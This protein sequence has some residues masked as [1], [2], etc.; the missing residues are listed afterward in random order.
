L[1]YY[2]FDPEYSYLAFLKDRKYLHTDDSGV[3]KL[4]S[5]LP[6]SLLEIIADPDSL[7]RHNI[8]LL[9]EQTIE[10]DGQ[11]VQRAVI[12][13]LPEESTES[14]PDMPASF[15]WS[16]ADRLIR[17]GYMNEGLGVLTLQNTSKEQTRAFRHFDD[18]RNAFI[19]K[20]YPLALKEINSALNGDD[21]GPGF[22]SEWR[23]YM[24]SGIL[25]L[26][27]YNC[28]TDLVDLSMARDDFINAALFAKA[29]YPL[30]SA[31]AYLAASWTAYCL[32]DLK[33]ALEHAGKALEINP[34]LMESHYLLARYQA[35]SNDLDKAFEYLAD[36]IGLHPFYALK[37]ASDPV[38]L[39]YHTELEAFLNNVRTASYDK[40]RKS[41]L[42][43]MNIISAASL[44]A[45][46]KEVI[47]RF[48]EEKSLLEV[49]KSQK[50]WDAFKVRPVFISKQQEKFKIEHEAVVRE[51]VP[52]NEKV[53]VRP[54]TFFRKEES[55]LVT[56]NR[57]VERVKKTR[58]DV[59]I[60]KDTFKFFTGKV[61][62][63]YNMV[64]VD[65]GKFKMGDTLG[66]GRIDEKPIQDVELSPY[67]ICAVQVTQKLWNMVMN[68]NPSNFHGYDL[69]VEH[70]SWYDCIE[71]CNK[72][73]LLAGLTPCYKIEYN[74][75]DTANYNRTDTVKWTVECDWAANGYR[76]PTEAE[77]E[78]AAK[79]GLTSNHYRYAGSDDLNH[80]CWHKDNSQ[81]KSHNVAQKASNELGIYD[82]SGNVWEWCWDW[83]EGY[84]QG[85]FK[86][87]QGPPAGS[88][89]ILRGGSWADNQNYQRV[90]SRGKEN[91]TGRYSSIGLRIVRGCF[92]KKTE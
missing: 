66:V 50:E 38:F 28:E 46:I 9:P 63:E 82:M 84:K 11:Q 62:I 15:H 74:L 44:P 32:G 31:I 25:R 42:S 71:F 34:K 83:Y 17:L 45:D 61:L 56:K 24:L 12:A 51:V 19:F 1:S 21:N 88:Y 58:Y 59:V 69:P 10:Q 47:E 90:A 54:A 68:D 26:G 5:T 29:D 78:F 27:F 77:W 91:P 67:L 3:Q 86:D 2:V 36:A 70:V 40:F 35:E 80:V 49:G 39:N 41:I 60:V 87:P 22:R 33:Q 18:A 64:R 81:Y 4:T 55:K 52:Y 20:N 43:D 13:F 89:R 57:V 48:A 7:A 6:Q 73:S 76:L 92:D 75:P 53:I 23:F 65:G 37:A 79:G 16:M 8:D 85:S 30:N 72:L 14:F